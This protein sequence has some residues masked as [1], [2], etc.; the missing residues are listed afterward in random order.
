LQQSGYN[1]EASR[2]KSKN[3]P[4]EGNGNMNEGRDKKRSIG[5]AGKSF[6]SPGVDVMITIFGDFRL[7]KSAFFDKAM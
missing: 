2:T 7:K 1:V 3:S 4:S 5:E 6:S